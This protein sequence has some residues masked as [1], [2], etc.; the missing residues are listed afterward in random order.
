MEYSLH[1]LNKLSILKNLKL[2]QIIETLNL[3]GFEVDDSYEDILEINILVKDIRLLLKIPA[4]REDL[5]I[6]E[7]FLKELVRLFSLEKISIWKS[8]KSY[9]FNLLK[10]YYFS[11]YEYNSFQIKSN[12][13]D[14]LIYNIQIISKDNFIS[15]KWIQQKLKKNCIEPRNNINDLINLISLEWGQTIKISINNNLSSSFY[16]EKLKNEEKFHKTN[17]DSKEFILPSNSIVLKNDLD[18]IQSC[19]G[20]ISPVSNEDISNKILNIQ[21]IFYDIH[22]NPLNLSLLNTK[23]STRYLRKTFLQF[24]RISIQRFLT[25]FELITTDTNI[26]INRYKTISNSIKVEETKIL[27]L[28]KVSLINFLKIKDINQNIFIKAGL[29][30][31]CETKNEFYFEVPNTRKDLFREIDLIEEY[32]RF[33]GYKNFNEILPIKN[34][35]IN[36]KKKNKYK[37]L[38]QFFINLG[39]NEIVNSSIEENNKEH[40]NSVV[41]NNPLNNEF[42]LLRS[43]LS[44]KMLQIFENNVRMGFLH[45]NFFEIGRIFKKIQNKI[46]EED[47]FAAIF[48]PI[49][50]KNENNLGLDWYINKGIIESLFTFFGYKEILIEKIKNTNS[51]YHPTRSCLFKINNR[52]LGIFG[53]INPVFLITKKVVYSIELN[54]SEF[55]DSQL[56]NEIIFSKELSKYPSITKDLSFLISKKTNFVELQNLLKNLTKHL[57]NYYLFDIYFQTTESLTINVGIR[58]EFQSDTETLT[59]LQIEKE[60]EVIKNLLQTK[61]NVSFNK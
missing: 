38:K 41:L 46:I 32:S 34:S 28:K 31:I 24:F 1:Y 17:T 56:S 8:F 58:F 54:L 35:L 37:F 49:F 2:T 21:A 27:K 11:K 9:Y 39:F 30:I 18:E 12:I 15:P 14:I 40:Q 57:K 5:L 6:E 29:T 45:T 23:L 22:S 36:N 4:N 61:F 26:K 42:F 7:L 53:E 47:R 10:Q 44:T 20:Y 16:V 33:I 43:D 19:L 55:K 3:I 52:I 48:E 25:I 60:I 13:D 51:I 59:N 50:N